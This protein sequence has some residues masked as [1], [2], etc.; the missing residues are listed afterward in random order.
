MHHAECGHC[1]QRGAGDSCDDRRSMVGLGAF[2]DRMEHGDRVRHLTVSSMA[3]HIYRHD[4]GLVDT[5]AW[6]GKP[7][8]A[9]Y[10]DDSI[11][12]IFNATDGT[13]RKMKLY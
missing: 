4:L 10:D 13:P 6:T 11:P 2:S 3:R 7:G 5:T 8:L 12:R 9:G 1:S